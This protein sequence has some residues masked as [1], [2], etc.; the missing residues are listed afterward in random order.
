MIMATILIAG[1]GKTALDIGF[2]FLERGHDVIWVS[3]SPDRRKKLEKR[4]ARYEKRRTSL[5]NGATQGS[6]SCGLPDDRN[7]PAADVI[8][9]STSEILEKKRRLF[10]SLLEQT[11]PETLLF[12]NSSSFQPEKIADGCLGAHFLFPLPITGL[13][14]LIIPHGCS[15]AKVEQARKFLSTNGLDILEQQ[16]GSGF[17]VNRLLLPLQ[18]EC[19]KALVAGVPA[20]IVDEASRC[21]IFPVGQLSLMDTIGLDIIHTA[22][23][24]Y[25]R[26]RPGEASSDLISMVQALDRLILLGKKG[27]K[28]RDGLLMGAPLPWHGQQ[29]VPS[30]DGLA[31]IFT[32]TFRNR[33]RQALDE[34]E[35]S[36]G[37]LALVFDRVF[38][39]DSFELHSFVS[40]P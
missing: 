7:L 32:A 24:Q 9:E 25:S 16:S 21:S 33:C 39:A 15:P 27:R 1:S 30:Y 28:N 5:D 12:S 18:A 17:L 37:D 31:D 22:V 6:A 20:E 34:A 19:F 8:I 36:A 29:G 10:I 4:L 23:T 14:E 26:S 38:Q 35:I 40:A 13:V 11:T 2:Y 3:G